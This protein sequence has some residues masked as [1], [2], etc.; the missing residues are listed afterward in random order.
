MHRMVQGWV[1]IEAHGEEF[2]GGAGLGWIPIRCKLS[3]QMMT[4][5]V[6]IGVLLVL[7][8]VVQYGEIDDDGEEEEVVRM[9]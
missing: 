1:E 9:E 6:V 2:E 3:Y 5:A 4:F 7:W 8:C